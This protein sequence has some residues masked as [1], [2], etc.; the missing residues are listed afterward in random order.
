MND[1]SRGS[2]FEVVEIRFR[3]RAS[4]MEFV[5]IEEQ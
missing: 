3:R 4:E 1:I 5:S 2:L